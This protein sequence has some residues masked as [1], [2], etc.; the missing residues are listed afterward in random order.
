MTDTT[1]L[2]DDMYP[3]GV[4]KG[5]WHQACRGGAKVSEKGSKELKTLI[6]KS[7]AKEETGLSPSSLGSLNSFFDSSLDSLV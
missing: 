4:V 5:S 3:N 6:Q 7:I 1:V 2:P